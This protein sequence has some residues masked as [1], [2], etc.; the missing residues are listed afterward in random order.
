MFGLVKEEERYTLTVHVKD[1][2]G[3]PVPADLTV[4]RLAGGEDAR[5]AHVGD[6]GTLR[7]RLEPGTYTLATFLDVRGGH[8]AD[9]SASASSRPPRSAWTTTRTSPWTAGSCARS[10]PPW[11]GAPRPASC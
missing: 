7:L 5:P 10:G 9:S 6:S 4:Q 2:D 11:T 1:R 3:A 8:G